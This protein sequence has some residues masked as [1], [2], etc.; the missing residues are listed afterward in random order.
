VQ[1]TEA[2]F[3]CDDSSILNLQYANSAEIS[4]INKGL[5][6]RANQT[7]FGFYID[8]RSGYWAKS[9]DEDAD[10]DVP[11][12]VA[13]PVRIVPIVRDHKNALLFRFHEPAAYAPETIATVQHALM[14]GIEVVFQLEEGEIL[15]E[16][17]PARDNRRAVL[18]YEATEGGAGVLSRLVEDPQ[19]LDKVAREALMLMHFEK[20]DEA[21]AAGDAKLL[22]SRDGEACVRGCYRCLLSYFNQPDHELIDRTSDEAKQTL[23]D[24]ARGQ[25]VLAVA[26]NQ[27]SEG[28]DWASAFKEA[29]L[30]PPDA[31]TVSFSGQEMT[32]AWRSH[33]V[34]TCVD[35]LTTETR[36]EGNTGR[37]VILKGWPPKRLG[38][39]AA[40]VRETRS[41]RDRL[42]YVNTN[43]F[44]PILQR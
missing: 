42:D 5:K 4:R 32:F 7:V 23:I 25:V 36:L 16:P 1:I 44:L 43:R 9:D 14:R 38:D 8:P 10:V 30:P 3:R 40:A 34:A 35:P 28:G 13:K 29:G 18:A 31:S 12:D 6:R 39:A 41:R 20:V 15:G 17:L 33:F 24:L 2:E 11:P 21:I 26:P 27:P 19:A 37:W 22:V